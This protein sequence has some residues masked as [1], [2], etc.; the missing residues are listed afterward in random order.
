MSL[1]RKTVLLRYSPTLILKSVSHDRKQHNAWE[2]SLQYRH[3]RHG[4]HTHN[5]SVRVYWLTTVWI[6]K[7]NC[8]GNMNTFSFT[9]FVLRTKYSVLNQCW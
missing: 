6:Y 4:I 3:T 7:V 8:V 1:Q 5:Y 9:F 2:K